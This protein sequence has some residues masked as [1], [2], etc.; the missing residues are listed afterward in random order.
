[1]LRG[2]GRGG[3]IMVHGA[4]SGEADEGCC[5]RCGV[6]PGAQPAFSLAY[7]DEPISH[8][9][10]PPPLGVLRPVPSTT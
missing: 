2:L 7:K 1:M 9:W 4:E 3:R 6:L 8:L 10:A 5:Q